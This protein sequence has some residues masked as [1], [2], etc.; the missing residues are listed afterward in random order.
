MYLPNNGAPAGEAEAAFRDAFKRLRE[1]KPVRLPVGTQVSQNNVAK[2]AGC[3][4]SALRKSRYPGLIREIQLWIE[5][6]QTRAGATER[7]S[8][9]S[10]RRR[11]RTLR[12]QLLEL[13]SQRDHAAS[14]LIEADSKILELTLENGRLQRQ[15][16]ASN[17]TSISSRRGTDS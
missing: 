8:A 10:R 9:L 13:K 5:Q 1:G 2:E 3:D 6:H 16:P 12:E 17:V 14:L 4:P 11:N 7:Q 15:L